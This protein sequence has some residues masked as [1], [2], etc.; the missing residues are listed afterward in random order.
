[1]NQPRAYVPPE[2]NPSLTLPAFP[3]PSPGD[4][5]QFNFTTMEGLVGC[6]AQWLPRQHVIAVIEA[7]KVVFVVRKDC[8]LH[9]T[10]MQFLKKCEGV[11]VRTI[12]DIQS[13]KVPMDWGYE[14][15]ERE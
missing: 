10:R 12:Q 1:M 7:E 11:L 14:A 8:S 9:E 2:E 6:F 5:V 3:I 4:T 15:P 13:G